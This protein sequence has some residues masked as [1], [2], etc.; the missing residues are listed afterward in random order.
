LLKYQAAQQLGEIFTTLHRP[1]Q[2]RAYERVA[3]RI[4]AE[5]PLVFGGGRGLL[6]SATGRNAMPDVWGSAYGIYNGALGGAE[7]QR[8][9]QL[10]A[11]AYEAGTLSY[12]GHIRHLL[13]TDDFSPTC[14]WEVMAKTMPKG[15]YQNGGYWATQSVGCALRSTVSGRIWL[16]GWRRNLSPIFGR[17]IFAAEGKM[18]PLTSASS[19][20][21]ARRIQ[22]I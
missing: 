17:R 18:A 20:A 7:A 1:D 15:R 8:V 19:R 12:H 16:A 10:L 2:A 22:S 14:L 9:A 21:S 5:L 13:T 4:R 3:E 11:Q 6:R